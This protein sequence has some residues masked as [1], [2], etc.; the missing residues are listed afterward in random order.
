MV[1]VDSNLGS[2]QGSWDAG[3][4]LWYNL[5]GHCQFTS[6]GNTRSY[7]LRGTY[8]E[9]TATRERCRIRLVEIYGL[10]LVADG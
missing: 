10:E 9:G 5:K 8:K 4:M 3:R 1:A 6:G 7:N 2:V